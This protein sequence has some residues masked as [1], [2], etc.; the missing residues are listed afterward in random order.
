MLIN[1]I[2]LPTFKKSYSVKSYCFYNFHSWFHNSDFNLR[3]RRREWIHAGQ[4]ITAFQVKRFAPNINWTL[5]ECYPL[6]FTYSH[7]L[8]AGVAEHVTTEIAVMPFS[9]LNF[10]SQYYNFQ[11][12]FPF[13]IFTLLISCF[14]NS[15]CRSSLDGED[16]PGI[17]IYSPYV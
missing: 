6:R 16:V 1:L 13:F 9:N 10:M 3:Y 12:N 4:Q 11:R 2:Y 15:L 5:T 14:R 7:S 17:I 8:V